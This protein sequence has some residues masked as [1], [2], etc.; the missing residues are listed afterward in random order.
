MDMKK[1]PEFLRPYFWDVDFKSLD[2]KGHEFLVIKR[3]LDRG[4]TQAIRWLI[5]EYGQEAIKQV[6]MS[7][8]DLA[9][10]TGNLWANVWGLNK[11]QIACLNKPYSP[12]PFGLSS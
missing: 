8:R 4:N 12:I 9:P 6:V 2:K 10:Q 11:S 7:S 3:L 5:D 1:L